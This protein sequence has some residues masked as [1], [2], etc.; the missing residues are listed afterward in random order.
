MYVSVSLFLLAVVLG[1]VIITSQLTFLRK[2]ILV[3]SLALA[4][5]L[6]YKALD[7]VYGFPTA[8]EETLNDTLVISFLISKEENAIYIWIRDPKGGIP[9]SYSLPY[10]LKLNNFLNQMRTKHGGN[11]FRA[12]IGKDGKDGKK[13]NGKEGKGYGNDST[14]DDEYDMSEIP[15]LPPKS[16]DE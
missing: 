13:G 9:R 7:I 3:S 10:N 2:I 14:E 12:R 8:L 11:A 1:F 16:D 5:L 15:T 6:T 4:S